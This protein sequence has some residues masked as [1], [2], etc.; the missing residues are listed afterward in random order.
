MNHQKYLSG[1]LLIILITILSVIAPFSTDM[2]LPGLPE[3]V[4]YFGTTDAVL[5][6][7]LYGFMLFMA[8]GILVLG[9]VSDKYGRKP[10][11]MVTLAGYTIVS[12][13]CAFSGSVWLFIF[14]RVLQG[15]AAGGMIVISTALIKD[16]FEEK[17]RNKILTLTIVMSVIGPLASPIIGAY[18]IEA[19]NWQ[20][21]LIFPALIT[22]V[23]FVMGLFFSESLPCEEKFTGSVAGV[24]KRLPA[25]CRNRSFTLFL[26]AT[27]MFSPAFMC[28]LSVSS[29]IF[30]SGFGLSGTAYSYFLAFNVIAGTISM[31]LIQRITGF[32]GNRKT[33]FLFL[34]LALISGALMLCFGHLNPYICLLCFIPCG[35]AVIGIRPYA[36]SILLNQYSGDTGSVSS[37]FNFMMTFTGC[38]GM[39][40]GTLPWPDYITGLGVCIL[41]SALAAGLFWLVLMKSGMQLKG[42]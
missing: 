11:L 28:F 3:I 33:G 21:T 34:A 27:S 26:L 19:V 10:V 41:G 25:L 4:T 2:Y 8:L 22:I 32:I 35:A 37:L 18:L 9:P 14:L 17:K 29:Y 24:L 30:V 39:A 40:A 12:I 15:I 36:L 1:P 42:L 6:M 5:N 23:S 7:T 20:A 38:L 13:L 31:L 16:C